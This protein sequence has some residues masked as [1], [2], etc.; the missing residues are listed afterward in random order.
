MPK[1]T[2]CGGEASLLFH[3]LWWCENH[4]DFLGEEINKEGKIGRK[5]TEKLKLKGKKPEQKIVKQKEKIPSQKIVDKNEE[6]NVLQNR[7]EKSSQKYQ[8][9]GL[10]QI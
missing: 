7:R 10:K 1:C 2:I 4:E 8:D 5:K 3:G 9:L 6:I